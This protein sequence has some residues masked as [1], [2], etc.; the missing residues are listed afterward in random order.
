MRLK[1]VEPIDISLEFDDGQR[2]SL[3]GL[4]TISRDNLNE[5]TDSDTIALFRCGY[6]QA[7]I[8]MSISLNQINVLARRRNN[9]L[10]ARP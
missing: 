8:T 4:Y 1:L 5:L 3:D 7:A 10:T 2:L 9:R 6:L